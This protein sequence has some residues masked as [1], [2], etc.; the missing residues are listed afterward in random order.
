[1]SRNKDRLGGHTPEPAEAPQQ[2]VEKAFDP[3]SFV[4]PTEFVELPSKGN[5]PAEHPLFGKEVLEIRFMTAKEEDILSSQT[6]LKKGLAIERMLDSLI[7]DK[8]I[9]AQELLVGDRNA[10]IIAARISGYGANYI[11][12]TVCQ[13]CGTR[14]QVDF[15]LNNKQFFESSENEK[16]NL[17]KLDNGNFQTKM[18]FSKFQ[19]EFRLLDGKDE[20]FLTKLIADKKKRKMSETTLT[21]QFK[22]MIVS[23]EGYKD[24][25]I[26]SK[27]VDNMPTLDSRHFK[28]AYKEASP[29]VKVIHDFECN[30]CGHTQE[31]EVPFNTDFFWPDR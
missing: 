30:S 21:D 28:A 13:S 16:L 5:Y 8:S 23:I 12:Q 17:V 26:I 25:S 18:P 4:A 2:P 24:K 10:L 1:M 29:D 9:K 3:L 15:D 14:C 31:M 20:Q 19:V 22:L 11:T 7:I 27:Y 6:L